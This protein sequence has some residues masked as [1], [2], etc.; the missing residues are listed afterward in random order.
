MR[1]ALPKPADLP[2][3]YYRPEWR[4][5]PTCGAVL[6]RHHILWR[7]RLV[8]LTGREYVTSW[9]YRCSNPGC[10]AREILHRSIQAEQLHL[11]RGQFGRDVVVQVGHWRFW[12]H[13]T[14]TEIH[15]R[16]VN[17]LRLPIC[18]RE[19]LNLLGDFLALLRAAQP[20]K[21]IVLRPQLAELGGLVVSIDGMQ[22]EKGHLC[23]YV[24]REPRMGLTLSAENLEDS[25]AAM[26][27]QALLK[28]LQALAH[29]LAL[30]ILGIVSDAQ[31]SIRLAVQTTLPGIP[32]HCCHF[33]CLRD[34]GTLT[35]EADRHMKTA[36]KQRMRSPL[37]HLE[38][39]IGRLPADDRWRPIL[40]DYAAAIHSTLLEGGV[41]PFEL[42]GVRIFDDLSAL[43]ASLQRCREKG[44]I[45]SWIVCSVS[46]ICACPLPHNENNWT[47]SDNGSL[48]WSICSTR[49]NRLQVGRWWLNRSTT[50]WSSYRLQPVQRA[51]SSINRWQPTST[52]PSV[53]AGGDYSPATRWLDCH[54]PITSW[55]RS[56]GNS[57]RD[58]AASQAAG[59]CTTS[60]CGT[61]DLQLSSTSLRARKHSWL[62][63]AKSHRMTFSASATDWAQYRNGPKN[64]TAFATNRLSSS[65]RSRPGGLLVH[66][67]P[68]RLKT[69]TN[70]YAEYAT[71]VKKE[72]AE[73]RSRSRAN[74]PRRRNAK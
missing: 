15:D 27:Q 10:R 35:F 72:R 11:G 7:K 70:L 74:A 25:G 4:S 60:L 55:K 2:R 42:G 65:K 38:A 49:P 66:R 43:A 36:L 59:M 18:E 53:T 50:V 13:M 22:P 30:P 31:E 6:K 45:A 12:Q 3:R 17:D 57:K 46:P 54:V 62:G 61:D 21:I 23:L 67:R 16:L 71:T 52:K 20:A 32:H 69:F 34:A 37:G 29:Q 26:I 28:P 51:T 63:C 39:S 44:G 47:N 41:A 1:H 40:A 24:L 5:C 14:V 48:T 9:G 73:S 56:C 8:L 68:G 19:V 33:H 64:A 58:S